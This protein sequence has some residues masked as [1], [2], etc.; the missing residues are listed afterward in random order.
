M[1][2]VLGQIGEAIGAADRVAA[3]PSATDKQLID[4]FCGLQNCRA[5]FMEEVPEIEG[6]HRFMARALAGLGPE[7]GFEVVHE[8]FSSR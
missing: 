4:A 5:G 3:D 7:A 2:L 8:R 6:W 1:S